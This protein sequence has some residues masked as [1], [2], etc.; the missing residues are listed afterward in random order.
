MGD[1][2]AVEADK[3]DTFNED[4]YILQCEQD[5]HCCETGFV[6]PWGQAFQVNAITLIQGFDIVLSLNFS[7]NSYLDL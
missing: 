1:F 2:F 3:R 6:D 4:F 5:V 7:S